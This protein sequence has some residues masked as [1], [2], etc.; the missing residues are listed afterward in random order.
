M[1]EN[2]FPDRDRA[3]D[4]PVGVREALG[5]ALVII[6][7]AMAIWVFAQVYGMF[8]DPH[9]LTP[10]KKLVSDHLEGS[11]SGAD[12]NAKLVI[13]R[14]FLAYVIPILLLVVASGVA[15]ILVTG[16]ANLAYGGYQRFLTRVS[17]LEFKLNRAIDGVK[18]VIRRS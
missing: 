5:I 2:R 9:K 10:F 6:G 17:A 18:D 12:V 16:G 8:R 13:P 3:L 15:S 1:D 14:E 7:A 11:F 4:P